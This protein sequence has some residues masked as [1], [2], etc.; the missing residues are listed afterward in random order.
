MN[1]HE[2]ILNVNNK[3]DYIKFIGEIVNDLRTNPDLWENISLDSYLEA[4]RSWVE[5]MDGWEKTQ[6]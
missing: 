3:D 6:F 2:V 5:D 1:L 4:M